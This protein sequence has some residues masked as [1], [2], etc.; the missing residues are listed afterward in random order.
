[1]EE[2]DFLYWVE[3][4]SAEDLEYERLGD[5]IVGG[6]EESGARRSEGFREGGYEEDVWEVGRG[7]SW[8]GGFG[9]GRRESSSSSMPH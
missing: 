7:W 2:I 9:E 5:G 6:V 4:V 3:G 8:R 1:M